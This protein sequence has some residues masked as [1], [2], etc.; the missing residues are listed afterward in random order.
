MKAFQITKY[1]G[2][3][4]LVE[5]PTPALGPTDVLVKITAASLNQLD[6]MLRVGTFKAMIPY[7]MP[8]M[9]GNDFAGSITAVG[10]QVSRFKVGDSVYAKP[11]QN[12]IGTFAEYIA[13][14]Q[15]VLAIAPKSISIIEAASLPLVGL[16][17]WQALVERGHLATGQK[18]LIHGGAGGVGSIAIQLAKSLGAFVATTVGTNNVEFAKSLG[19]DLVIDYKS[20]DF[21]NLIFGYDLVLDTQGGETL[22]KSLAVLRTGGKAI[23]ISGPPDVAFAR[24]LKLNSVLQTVVKLLSSKVKKRAKS[25]GVN[26]EF[27]FV[28]AN[29]KQLAE[30]AKLVDAK[31]IKP[32]L[33]SEIIFSETPKALAD[34]AAGKLGRGK[35]VVVIQ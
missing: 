13:V 35:A 30:L 2:P 1:N 11:S 14:D 26:Y 4:H 5:L 8:L 28:E 18:V 6:E 33:G 27:L 22:L 9:L 21:S 25:L 31:T 32:V 29:G 23:G 10:S 19:A 7:T 16:T 17:A 3:L 34:L 15:S 24:Q 20:Q 12:R